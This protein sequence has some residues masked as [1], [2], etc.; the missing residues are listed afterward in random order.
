[1][2]HPQRFAIGLE[3]HEHVVQR[4]FHRDRA[5]VR[6]GI[7]AFD[8]DPFIGEISAPASSSRVRRGTPVYSMLWIMPWVNCTPFSCA[9]AHSMPVLAAHSQK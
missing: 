2:L 3:G 4:L 7:G 8:I 5:T 1:M 9:P 6:R